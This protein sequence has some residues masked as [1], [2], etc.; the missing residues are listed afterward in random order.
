MVEFLPLSI[1]REKYSDGELL[2][3]A[4]REWLKIDSLIAE[5][6]WAGAERQL[7]ADAH[8]EKWGAFAYP[9]AGL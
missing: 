6:K 4:K 5:K 9:K 2:F 1:L 8:R 7:A 3:L